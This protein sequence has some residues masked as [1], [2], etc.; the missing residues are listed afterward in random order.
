MKQALFIDFDG[1]LCRDRFWRG[2]PREQYDLIQEQL[3]EGNRELM[4]QWM[5]GK[6]TS[7]EVNQY[8][9]ELLGVPYE[10][11]WQV[12]VQDAKAMQVSK[13]ALQLISVLRERFLTILITVNMD[14]FDRF[15]VPALG[16]DSHFDLIVN[17][18]NEG[19]FKFE[20]DGAMFADAAAKLGAA[21][22][23]AYLIDDSANNCAVFDKL[24]GTGFLV[25]AEHSTYDYLRQ[26]QEGV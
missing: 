16:L 21:F 15:T 1:V 24:G 8:V 26:L 19:R 4:D 23:G 11:V 6:R 5:R 20:E 7:E 3:I 13:E 12:F 22:L 14:S 17:S 18:Y 2:L 9:S 10:D 25:D